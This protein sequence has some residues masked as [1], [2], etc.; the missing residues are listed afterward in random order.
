M[1]PTFSIITVTWNAQD[2]IAPTL[3]SVREQQC[4]DFEYLVIDGASTDNT[5]R[6]V[7]EAAIPGTRIISEPDQGLY[8]AMNKAIAQARGRYLVWMNA[9]D[10]F[11]AP[12]SLGRL[13]QA[14]QD[15]PGVIYGQ[16]Q[17]VDSG[18]RVVGMRHLTAPERLSAKSFE[19]GM[20]VCHQAFVARRDLCPPYDVRYRYSADY[21]WCIRVL[22]QSPANAYVGPEPLVSFLSDGGLTV[23]NHRRSL[24]ERYRIMCQHYGT[25]TAVLRHLSFVPRAVLRK[26][27][28]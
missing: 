1:N 2:V 23:K 11:A 24:R 16:T 7:N 17:L 6:M 12:N 10:A 8:Y 13:A 28:R 21:D 27:A 18:R 4:P 25:A 9:G 15:N 19:R 20:L 26:L 3:Q 5:L 22:Q 14:A